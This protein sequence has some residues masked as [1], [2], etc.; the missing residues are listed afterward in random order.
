[1]GSLAITHNPIVYGARFDAASTRNPNSILPHTCLVR[2]INSTFFFSHS[3][4]SM[5]MCT[6]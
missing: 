3:L 1:M 2:V 4:D 6:T 5:G